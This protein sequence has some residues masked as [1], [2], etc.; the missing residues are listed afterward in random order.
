M[1]TVTDT[2]GVE[3]HVY[4][5]LYPSFPNATQANE[6]NTLNLGTQIY[7]GHVQVN[8]QQTTSKV[9]GPGIG[10]TIPEWMA[11]LWLAGKIRVQVS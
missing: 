10:T 2:N 9:R 6:N 5:V 1:K 3:Y 7:P 11:D 4:N 8:L